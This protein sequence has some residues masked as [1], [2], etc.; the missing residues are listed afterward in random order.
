M[1]NDN[2]SVWNTV[3][4][5]SQ[6]TAPDSHTIVGAIGEEAGNCKMKTTLVEAESHGIHSF[7]PSLTRS[8]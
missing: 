7:I 4:I 2:N 1:L 8:M 5:E 6:K 3:N